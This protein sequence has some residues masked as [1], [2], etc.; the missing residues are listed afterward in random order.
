MQK[1]AILIL[2]T[3]GIFACSDSTQNTDGQVPP[4]P[5]ES[6][7]NL[8]PRDINSIATDYVKL[9]LYVGQFDGDVVDAYYGPEALKPAKLEDT[10]VFPLQALSA[11]AK[12]L[13][14][15]LSMVSSESVPKD[16]QARLAMLKKQLIAIST[17]INM[18]G[19]QVYS[20]DEEANL[21]YDA[22]PLTI[23]KAYFD[24]LLIELGTLLPGESSLSDRYTAFMSQFVIPKDKIDIVFRTAI[25]EARKRTLSKIDLPDNENFVL[26]Y[27]TDKAWSGYNYYQGK[28]QSLIQINIDLPIYIGR[29]VDL[30]AHE[31]YPGHH[32]FNA[33]LE[34]NLVNNKQWIE[35]SVYQLFSPQSLIAEGSANYGIDV[36]F[37]GDSRLKYETEVLF[38][39]AGL[40]ASKAELF[41]KVSDIYS[42]LSFAG[43]EAA[44]QYLNGIITREEASLMLQTYQLNTPERA[45]QRTRFF[46]KYRSY[47]INYNL[48]LELV[49]D[50]VESNGGSAD[51]PDRRWEIFEELLSNPKTASMIAK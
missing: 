50:Y 21:L 22:Q 29:A 28:A 7:S 4:S 32:V 19:G 14:D 43:N 51:N 39:L 11:Q 35:F 48:G 31:G 33:L 45:A 23:E 2:L 36:A 44:R 34:H 15:E 41:Y 27:V 17:K 18:L 1:L 47:V 5:Q 10:S 30:A 37:P 8:I 20:F 3:T 38:P 46:D 16:Q 40:D 9:V 6:K 42:Q 49:K 24:G 12:S 13:S 26:E 25:A